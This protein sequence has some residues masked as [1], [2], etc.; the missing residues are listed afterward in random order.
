MYVFDNSPLSVLFKNY[1]RK[2]FPTLWEHFGQ[3][4]NDGRLLSTREVKREIDISSVA[5]LRDWADA[6]P[7]IFT[8]PTAAEGAA[9]AQI[10]AVPH[11]QQNIERQKL[12]KGGLL[13]DPFVI[14]KGMTD[15]LTVVTMEL[16]KPHAAKIPNICVH[17]NVPCM[18]LEEFMEAEGWEF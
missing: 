5:D 1:Y 9:V 6:N 14:A 13:A 18:T 10:Y 17:F 12:L 3:L 15:G 8:T 4:V 11:F 7:N 16:L 2:R